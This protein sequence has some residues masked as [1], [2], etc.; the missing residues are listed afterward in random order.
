[1]VLTPDEHNFFHQQCKNWDEFF[2]V[3]PHLRGKVER[4]YRKCAELVQSNNSL[5]IDMADKNNA[6]EDID[7]VTSLAGMALAA[8]GE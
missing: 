3:Y 4:A 6:L 2:D 5:G 1:M 8:Q 7:S